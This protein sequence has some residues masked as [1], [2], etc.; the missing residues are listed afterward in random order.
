MHHLPFPNLST[1]QF[2]A[3]LVGRGFPPRRLTKGL[4]SDMCTPISP[5]SQHPL[6]RLPLQPSPKFPLENCYQWSNFRSAVRIRTQRFD[7]SSAIVLS[8]KD[9]LHLETSIDGDLRKREIVQEVCCKFNIVARMISTSFTLTSYISSRHRDVLNNP[10]T[11]FSQ[12]FQTNRRTVLQS[13]IIAVVSRPL[14]NLPRVD[15]PLLTRARG[16]IPFSEPMK[17]LPMLSR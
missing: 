13:S 3:E 12:I 4:T 14:R 10:I 1:I 7:Q 6:S 16:L 9:L 17:A 8:S 2:Q 15:L 11:S 5:A